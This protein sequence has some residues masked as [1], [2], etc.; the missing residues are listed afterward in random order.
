MVHSYKASCPIAAPSLSCKSVAVTAAIVAPLGLP[1]SLYR[2]VTAYQKMISLLKKCQSNFQVNKRSKIW[3]DAELDGQAKEVRRPGRGMYRFGINVM[4]Y[5]VA[6]K[7][8][9]ITYTVILIDE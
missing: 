7:V 1:K 6:V 5:I 8:A 3:W 2:F 9:W 4:L